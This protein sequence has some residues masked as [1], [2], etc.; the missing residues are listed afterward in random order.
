MG[1]LCV[2]FSGTA[3]LLRAFVPMFCSCVL[4]TR[5]AAR[6]CR[7]YARDFVYEVCTFGVVGVSVVAAVVLLYVLAAKVV[8]F[9]L[10]PSNANNI[11]LANSLG[12]AATLLLLFVKD[13]EST[14][15]RI[16]LTHFPLNRV[17]NSD[18]LRLLLV[19]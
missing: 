14:Q 13:G 16:E 3:R 19:K 9:R 6:N 1:C 8:C 7:L 11:R 4:R 15:T 2:R 17:G 5:Y 18:C 10:A 12:D